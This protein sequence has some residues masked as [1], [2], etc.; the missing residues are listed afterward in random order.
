M[1]WARIGKEYFMKVVR[2]ELSL[3]EFKSKE[4]GLAQIGLTVDCIRKV[5]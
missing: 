4:I 1:L 5:Q 3:E 2:F